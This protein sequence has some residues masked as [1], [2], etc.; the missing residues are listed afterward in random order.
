MTAAVDA[1]VD[2]RT[3]AANFEPESAIWTP[4]QLRAEFGTVEWRSP[5]AALPSRSLQ[6]ADAVA[7]RM[8]H[9]TGTDVRIEGETGRVTDDRVVLPEFDAVLRHVNAAIEDGPLRERCGRIST[10]W[11]ST[12]TRTP[13]RR[14]RSTDQTVTPRMPARFG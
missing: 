9:L 11:G 14:R 10:G 2:R 12:W 7:T 4:V 1:G 6:L 8:D 3:V 13:G 5:D